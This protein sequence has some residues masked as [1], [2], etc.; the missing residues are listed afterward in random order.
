[1]I[2]GM[3]GVERRTLTE[4]DID[5]AVAEYGPII[6][7]C[8]RELEIDEDELRRLLFGVGVPGEDDSHR[9]E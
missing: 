7:Q 5:A 1:M 2:T 8:L 6:E 3:P 4:A 9:S